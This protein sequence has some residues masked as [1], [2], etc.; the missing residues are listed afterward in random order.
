MNGKGRLF[1][2]D[3]G[4]DKKINMPIAGEEIIVRKDI[5]I[6]VHIRLVRL[7]IVRAPMGYGKTM[8]LSKAFAKAKSDIAWLALDEMD[9]DPIRFWTYVITAIESSGK[10]IDKEK[11]LSFIKTSPPHSMIVDT[12]LNEMSNNPGKMTLILDDYHAI[13]NPVIHKTMNRFIDYLPHHIKIY[14]TSRNEVPLAISKWQVKGWVHEIGMKQLQFQLHE[15]KEFYTKRSSSSPESML[16]YQQVLRITEGWPLGIQLINLTGAQDDQQWEAKDS[17]VM[18]P[19][20]ASYLLHEI[21]AN[22]TPTMQDFLIRTSVLK[23]LTPLTCN[24]V[25]NRSDSENVLIE[26]EKRGLFINRLE[27]K[28]PAYRYHNLFSKALQDEMQQ[29]FSKDEIND[30]YVKTAYILYEQGDYATAIELAIK[31]ELFSV[32]DSWIE[33]NLVNIFLSKQTDMFMRWVLIL[34]KNS[35]EVQIETLV[36]YAFIF[37]MKYEMEKAA[38]LIREL[39]RRNDKTDWKTDDELEDATLLLEIVKV[40]MLF[41]QW[42]PKE[43][44]VVSLQKK[45]HDSPFPASS[46]WRK[47]SIIYNHFEPQLLRTSLGNRGKL[48]SIKQLSTFNDVLRSDKFLAHNLAGYS[49]GL[50]AEIF[51]EMNSL[52]ES[53][54]HIDKAMEYAN[55]NKD[56]GLSVP[57]YIVQA[58]IYLANKQYI[59]AQAILDH[60]IESIPDTNWQCILITMKALSYIREES[61]ERAEIE[62]NKSSNLTHQQAESG[63]EFWMLVKAR[64][65]MENDNIR[66]ALY[67]IDQVA[68]EAKEESQLTTVIEAKVLRALCM[69]KSTKKK[70]ALDT[71]HE[72]LELA[73]KSGY[74]RLFMDE[75]D[76][77]PLLVSYI[78]SRMTLEQPEWKAVPLVFAQSLRTDHVARPAIAVNGKTKPKLTPREEELIRALATGS[79]NKEIAE[80]LFLSEGTVRVYLSK[81][82]KKLNVNSRTQAILQAK[83]WQ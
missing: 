39:E 38:S 61:L 72:A 7:T 69:W 27:G 44:Q 1:V 49:H 28:R 20:V 59:K 9:N 62:L 31:G 3:N 34:R 10:A 64:L 4:A 67:Y 60:A 70:L 17:T 76:L 71:L 77:N 51:Y 82:Y 68:K 5:E 18:S 52:V 41:T 35:F 24:Y 11:L 65:H 15:V 26:I 48:A 33:D 58:K 12:L 45:I 81:V 42:G 55:R 46:R 75:K 29:R 32:A 37:A 36:V 56:A 50:R 78:K 40:F 21:I 6:P 8:L 83:D 23:E 16:F 43:K 47:V 25:M 80:Q 63:L 22:L 73:F 74:R 54:E 14:I 19:V 57:M 13:T 66:K 2:K 53:Q 79:S 30:I